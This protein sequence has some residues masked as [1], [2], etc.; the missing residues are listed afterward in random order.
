M[1]EERFLREDYDSSEYSYASSS[2]E[3]GEELPLDYDGPYYPSEEGDSSDD[4]DEYER[5]ES[6]DGREGSR[7][8]QRGDAG[9]GNGSRLRWGIRDWLYFFTFCTPHP[10]TFSTTDT[11]TTNFGPNNNNNSNNG[12]QAPLESRRARR[13]RLRRERWARI[14]QRHREQEFAALH[15]YL[16]LVIRRRMTAQ[17]VHRVCMAAEFCR[18]YLT[19][20]VS[21]VIM[22]AIVYGAVHVEASP[23]PKAPKTP[24]V[25]GA[26]A[27]DWMVPAGSG[28][29]SGQGAPVGAAGTSG[30]IS[31]RVPEQWTTSVDG[32]WRCRRRLAG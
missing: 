21:I 24:T 6:D 2:D 15:R 25:A 31:R 4:E 7:R 3:E 16:P 29:G 11:T 14:Q 12:S 32:V 30:G 18:F 1:L 9:V 23:S 20:L 22:G 19:I 13:R 26:H 8:R 5:F 10:R 27:R 17:D 28:G